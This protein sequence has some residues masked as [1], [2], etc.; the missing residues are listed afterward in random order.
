MRAIFEWNGC[1][2]SQIR[3]TDV[4]VQTCCCM[5]ET[6]AILKIRLAPSKQDHSHP[7]ICAHAD[8]H[9]RT[10]SAT[11]RVTKLMATA[12]FENAA[13]LTVASGETRSF[14]E[15]VREEPLTVQDCAKVYAGRW[16][17]KTGR[18]EKEKEPRRKEEEGR[19]RK[20]K[21]RQRERQRKTAKQSEN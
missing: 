1:V 14:V 10:T 12:T 4:I 9:S 2:D 5:Y 16:R 21:E 8:T 18:K 15:Q 6:R 11:A 19:R 7:H 20:G 3:A 17:E 13:W